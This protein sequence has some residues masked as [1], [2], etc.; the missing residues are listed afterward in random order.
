MRPHPHDETLFRILAAT[1]D[2]E[3]GNAGWSVPVGAM[4]E[5]HYK[6]E[7]GQNNITMTITN[8][9]PLDASGAEPSQPQPESERGATAA[10]PVS[11][12]ERIMTR[13]VLDPEQ[14]KLLAIQR[15]LNCRGAVKY[16]HLVRPEPSG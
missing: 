16:R 4:F 7:W 3:I 15:E 6:N 11:E 13:E 10:V 14:L 5:A 12:S 2:V 8:H 9:G 1:L